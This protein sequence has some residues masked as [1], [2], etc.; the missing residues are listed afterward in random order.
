MNS[1]I[2]LIGLVF[3]I[4]FSFGC[5]QET[6]NNTISNNS[7]SNEIDLCSG[8]NCDEG[9]ECIE[10][11]CVDELNDFPEFHEGNKLD[12]TAICTETQECVGEEAVLN[13]GEKCCIGEC[14][15]SI[16]EFPDFP[17]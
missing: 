11:N 9:F 17:E 4:V 1:K 14:I 2:I 3:L 15:E 12:C 7:I 5:V 13:T 6:N 8:I 16:G 10:G